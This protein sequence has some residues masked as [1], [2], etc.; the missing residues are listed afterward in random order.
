M[1]HLYLLAEAATSP[2]LQTEGYFKTLVYIETNKRSIVYF[3]GILFE[4]ISTGTQG[5]YIDILLFGAQRPC[6]YL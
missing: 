4:Y 1:I 5:L 6:S 3:N 2:E